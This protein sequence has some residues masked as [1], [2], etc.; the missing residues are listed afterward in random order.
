MQTLSLH[1]YIVIAFLVW[2]SSAFSSGTNYISKEKVSVCI[3]RRIPNVRPIEA[4]QGFL[5]FT[6]KKGGG[7]P[8]FCIVDKET[9]LKRNL[10]LLGEEILLNSTHTHKDSDR[11]I[12][13]E[14]KLT[15]L[16]PVWKS[17][18]EAGSHLGVVS[19]SSFDED[20]LNGCSGIEM[21]WNV[22]FSTLNR[23]SF[24]QLVTESSISDACDNLVAYVSEPILM[25]KRLSI[26]TQFSPEALAK[27]WLEFVWR[28]GGGLPL[29]LPPFALGGNGHDRIIVPPFLIERILEIN[30]TSEYT[31]IIYTVVNPSLITYPVFTHLGRVRFQ[32]SGDLR[33]SNSNGG[34]EEL[35]MI[36]QVSVRP[37]NN[38][39]KTFVI[40]FTES[41]VNIL[42]RNFKSH[43]EETG[44]DQIVKVFPPRGFLKE[45]GHLFQVRK[46]TWLGSVLFEHLRDNRS[47]MDQT[48]DLFK[49]WRWGK[50]DE[51]DGTLSWGV[52]GIS[53]ND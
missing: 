44:D 28:G 51:M 30:E 6:W 39:L 35:E 36:W 42:A 7:L 2:D 20:K 49:P 3:T 22:S 18:I 27:E 9:P 11:N 21:T 4:F 1:V 37:L 16:G 50:R 19:F 34:K 14:Y 26:Q 8:V 17:E 25:T 33:G 47:M 52:G 45:R 10:L 41:V 13:Q 24:W 29:P 12:V 23:Q 38:F 31:D 32:R 15:T 40:V 43:M 53:E 48:K 46:D 5:D